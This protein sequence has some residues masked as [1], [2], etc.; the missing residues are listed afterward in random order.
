MLSKARSEDTFSF[1][2]LPTD[3]DPNCEGWIMHRVSQPGLV[4]GIPRGVVNT[5]IIHT[6]TF[7]LFKTGTVN[8]SQ[9]TFLSRRNIVAQN[10]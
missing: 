1:R 7:V 6:L 5:K 10:E 3:E 4:D 2:C 8:Q 9:T